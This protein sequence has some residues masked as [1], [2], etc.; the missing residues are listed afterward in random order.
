MSVGHV[1]VSG[2]QLVLGALYTEA[3]SP[4]CLH[5]RDAGQAGPGGPARKWGSPVHIGPQAASTLSHRLL[6]MFSV[7]FDSPCIQT[8]S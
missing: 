4:C 5:L 8:H 1:L 7:F 6:R 2:F 3:A